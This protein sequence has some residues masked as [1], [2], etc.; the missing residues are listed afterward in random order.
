MEGF[1]SFKESTTATPSPISGF[2]GIMGAPDLLKERYSKR[3]ALVR[4]LGRVQKSH[5]AGGKAF[6][7]RY[8]KDLVK[9]D[10][11]LSCMP[12]SPHI[13][14]NSNLEMQS[15]PQLPSP[16]MSSE[17][18]GT[19]PAWYELYE[20]RQ[21]THMGKVACSELR[22]LVLNKWKFIDDMPRSNFCAPTPGKSFASLCTAWANQVHR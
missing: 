6:R 12:S 7:G 18:L 16:A 14:S 3:L 20:A 2:L 22:R 5:S 10:P 15:L 13:A 8:G 17:S 1:W 19:I 11:F 4:S 21:S 9:Q